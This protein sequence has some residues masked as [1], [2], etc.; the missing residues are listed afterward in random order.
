MAQENDEVCGGDE[1]FSLD[2]SADNKLRWKKITRETGKCPFCPKHNGENFR[3]NG[4]HPKKDKYKN[5][6]REVIADKVKQGE[7]KDEDN[8]DVRD[9]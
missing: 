5:K 9:D 6:G 3:T 4:R 2:M 1:D 7:H 8:I